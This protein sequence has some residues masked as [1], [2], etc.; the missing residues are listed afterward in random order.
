MSPT[1][2]HELLDLLVLGHRFELEFFELEFQGC[3]CFGINEVLLW[4]RDFVL[5]DLA[6]GLL[7]G[8]EVALYS[9]LKRLYF[10][11]LVLL[12]VEFRH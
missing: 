9:R 11:V 2:G 8:V 1:K 7:Q 6:D 3:F 4:K 5:V 12:D 10:R